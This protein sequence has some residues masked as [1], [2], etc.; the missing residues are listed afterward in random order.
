VRSYT[1]LLIIVHC[2]VKAFK[3]IRP[4]GNFMHHQAEHANKLRSANLYILWI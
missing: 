4:S 3:P 1:S 2:N